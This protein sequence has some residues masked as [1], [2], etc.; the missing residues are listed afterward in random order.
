MSVIVVGLEDLVA[1]GGP[2]L[3]ELHAGADGLEGAFPLEVRV[4][5]QAGILISVSMLDNE[6]ILYPSSYSV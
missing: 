1:A 4:I 2:L 5:L 6:K 3:D